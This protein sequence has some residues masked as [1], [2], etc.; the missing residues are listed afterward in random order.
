M[1][2]CSNLW[3]W[4]PRLPI[5]SVGDAALGEVDQLRAEVA[6]LQR[7]NLELRQQAGIGRADTPIRAAAGDFGSRKQHLGVEIRKLQAERFGRRLREA[8]R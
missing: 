5:C 7:E 1:A 2:R 8:S 4:S 3:N 6:G